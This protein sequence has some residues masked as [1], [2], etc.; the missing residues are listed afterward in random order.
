MKITIISMGKFENS[1]FKA[2]FENYAKRIK[3]RVE[4][5]E[6][7]LKN[8][9][10][11]SSIELK[12]REAALILKEIKPQ[13]K[14][15]ILDENGTEYKSRQF[16]TMLTNLAVRGDSNITFIIGGSDGLAEEIL[17]K[18]ATKISLGLMTFPH[19]MVRVILIEQLYRAQTIIE[20]HPYHRD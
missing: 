2:V 13:T 7:E 14:L 6:L 15:I 11:L 20:G 16:A 17:Q 1:P 8:A 10:S 19:L 12:T 3:W 5:K 18:P 4:L 9:Q